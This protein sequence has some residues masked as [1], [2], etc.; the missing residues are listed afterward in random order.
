[1]IAQTTTSSQV[2]V[3]LN[4]ALISEAS[5]TSR[6]VPSIIASVCPIEIEG[7]H[8]CLPVFHIRWRKSAAFGMRITAPWR[9]LQ[10]LSGPRAT[11][12]GLVPEFRAA[13]S[14][15]CVFTLAATNHA[16]RVVFRRANSRTHT[17]PLGNV[18]SVRAPQQA[19]PLL[20]SPSRSATY[21]VGAAVST[22]RSAGA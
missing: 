1:M 17:A 18:P 8:G 11:G 20:S 12:P 19:T 6:V 9:L 22:R 13:A 14:T 21:P 10:P 5:P 3:T 2:A 7:T 16:S 15:P 4:L